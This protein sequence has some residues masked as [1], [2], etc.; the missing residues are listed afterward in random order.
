MRWVWALVASG[1]AVAGA[2]S[3]AVAA[4][5]DGTPTAPRRQVVVVG[6]RSEA[7]LAA[8]VRTT[9]ATVLRRLPLVHAAELRVGGSLST[10]AGRSGIEYVEPRAPR[11]SH[12]EPA[13]FSARGAA[14]EWQFAAGHVDAVPEWVLRAASSLTIAVVDTGADLA[15]PD[16]AAKSPATYDTAHRDGEVSD[17]NGHGTFVASLAAG[18]VTNGDG[19]SGFGGDA[20]LLVVRSGGSDGTFSDVDEAAGI[21]YAVDHGAKIINLSVGGPGTSR[22]EQRAIDYAVAHGALL[23]AA[24]G[25]ERQSGNPVEYPAALL[26]PLGSNGLGGRGLSVGASTSSGL[27]ASFSNTGSYV[28][29][30][31]PGVDVFAA[32]SALSSPVFYPR[33]P[34][35]GSQGGLYGFASGTSFSAPEV[36]GA[37]ALVWA[38]NPALNAQAVAEILKR[39]ASRR[40]A[41][42]ADQ[43]FGVLDVGA[44]VA[45]ATNPEPVV[46]SVPRAQTRARRAGGR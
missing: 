20:R 16:L 23:V 10:L 28:S 24:A 42:S 35:A 19:I 36:S 32:V 40:G 43:A 13:L 18:S 31:A 33:V 14:V 41:W 17:A 37:A 12:V 29:L 34:L 7:D 25:N 1:V 5:G 4:A 30:L 38:A 15:A 45:R 8:A 46:V 6:Y 39:T 2:A 44:A 26:Q 9:Q 22:T 27:R 3:G 21:V 11:H